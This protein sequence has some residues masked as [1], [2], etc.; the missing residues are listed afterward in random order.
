MA[1]AQGDRHIARQRQIIQCLASGGYDPSPAKR[2]LGLFV[3]IQTRRERRRRDL[4]DRYYTDKGTM[5][6][7]LKPRPSTMPDSTFRCPHTGM[8]VQRTFTPDPAADPDIYEYVPCPACGLH[9][10]ANKS[11]GMLIGERERTVAEAHRIFLR[12]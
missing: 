2:L 12:R 5:G 1:Q 3:E 8:N 9:H 6:K 10:F 7:Q 11:T 4:I